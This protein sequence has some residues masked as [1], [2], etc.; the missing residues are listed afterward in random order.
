MDDSE[1]KKNNNNHINSHL[2]LENNVSSI[3]LDFI[4]SQALYIHYLV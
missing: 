4:M 2:E 1:Q 3:F